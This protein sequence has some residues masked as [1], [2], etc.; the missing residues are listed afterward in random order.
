[1]KLYELHRNTKFTINDDPTGEIITFKHID[2]MYSVC[3]N[4]NNELYHVVAWQEVTPV[5]GDELIYNSLQNT[6]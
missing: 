6:S 4:S 3:Y 5:T 1:M 2:G